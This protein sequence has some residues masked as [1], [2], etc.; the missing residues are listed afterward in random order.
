MTVWLLVAAGLVAQPV[1][2]P[3]LAGTV[4]DAK[5]N[6]VAGARVDISTAAPKMGP[7]V[8]CPS[9][10]LDCAKWARTDPQGRFIIAGLDPSLKFRVLVS[11]PGKRS[12]LTPLTDPLA[13]PLG[14]KLE[15][16]PK[17]VPPERLLLGEVVD[18]Q[19][20]PIEGALVDPAGAKTAERRWWGTV[21]V[22]PAVTDNEGQ[23]TLFLPA[24]YQ[25]LDLSVV[26]DG[27]AG[28]QIDLLA[29]GTKR[30]RLA[31]PTGTRVVG[32]LVHVG[33]RMPGIQIAV[34]QM[35]RSAGRHFIK[36]VA[37]TSDS[38]GRFAFDYLP[39]DEDYAIFSVAGEGRQPL[40]LTTKKFKAYAS[41]KE[42][43][44]GDLEL[45][46]ALR[47]AG[48]V[49]LPAGTI[50]PPHAKI[51]LSRDPAWDLIAAPLAEDGRF[52][53]GGLPPESYTVRVSIGGVRLSSDKLK[54]QQLD[55]ASF[56]LRLRE[57]VTDLRI[58]LELVP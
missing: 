34:V 38:D 58:P 49:E 40:V 42:R 26:A 14:V 2:R 56:G 54:Y 5:G 37:A 27:H 22:D 21:E 32:R 31:V 6:P 7:G 24:G 45:I 4:V 44:L 3:N 17:D 18:G 50:F 48:R 35:D 55:A 23:F 13:G 36:A 57:S 53:F 43:D 25:G 41:G 29:P 20:L 1:I 12:Q 11:A 30:H 46:A 9:C 8:F 19:G 39:A 51:V 15:D 16:L 47:L 28:A 33:M 52:E 10:Y